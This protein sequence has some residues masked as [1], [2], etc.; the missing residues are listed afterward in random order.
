MKC[1]GTFLVLTQLCR[2]HAVKLIGRSTSGDLSSP[3]LGAPCNEEV[4][5]VGDVKYCLPRGSR[6]PAVQMLRSGAQWE[7]GTHSYIADY[8]RETNRKGDIV[9]MGLFLGDFL[10]HM[11]KLAGPD[12]RVWGFEP[13]PVNFALAKGT[14]FENGL[15]NAF[16]SN[17]GGGDADGSLEFCLE[18]NNVPCGGQCGFQNM[19][20]CT[21]K[22]DVP[23]KKLDDVIP[24]GRSVSVIHLDVEGYEKY[25]MLGARRIINENRPLVIAENGRRQEIVDLMASMGYTLGDTLEANSF[26]YPSADTVTHE[27]MTSMIRRN[28]D[29]IVTRVGMVFLDS[30]KW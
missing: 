12:H 6:K 3:D 14:I 8:L 24:A 28:V 22:M 15:K 16:V 10:P 9:T 18:K 27:T 25:V 21:K 17:I 30:Q 23:V 11:S 5:T 19:Y 13:N 1:F 20:G 26:F 2:Q 7:P 4:A 29:D